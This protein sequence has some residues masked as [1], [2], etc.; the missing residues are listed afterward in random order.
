MTEL[1]VI[2]HNILSDYSLSGYFSVSPVDCKSLE[3]KQSVFLPVISSSP[4]TMSSITKALNN[5]LLIVE[6]LY[7]DANTDPQQS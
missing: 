4:G 1:G 5:H 6:W 7:Y 3:S 2:L